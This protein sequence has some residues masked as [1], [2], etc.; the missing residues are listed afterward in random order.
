MRRS[1]LL[2]GS[3]VLMLVALECGARL[4]L[5]PPRSPG[6]ADAFYPGLGWRGIPG[7]HQEGQDEA[8]PFNFSLNDQGLRGPSI[9]TAAG[10]PPGSCFQVVDR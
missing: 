9:P 3:A 1:A 8:G 2:I 7:H 10:G 5:A 6:A 4:V